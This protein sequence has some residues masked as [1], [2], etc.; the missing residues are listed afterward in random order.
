MLLAGELRHSG[1][2]YIVSVA[3]ATRLGSGTQ[4]PREDH[5]TAATGPSETMRHRLAADEGTDA[6]DTKTGL[7]PQRASVAAS[8]RL[9]PARPPTV[10]QLISLKRVGSPA[11][12]PDGKLRRLH[13]ARAQLGRERLR[14]RD[15]A[16]RRRDR[17]AP[18]VDQ[19]EE[20]ERVAELVAR[21]D[22]GSPSRPTA[23]TSSRSASSG[24]HA[25]RPN[26]SRPTRRR[27]RRLRLVARRQGRSPTR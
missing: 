24:R 22:D 17:H 9:G 2:G 27:R 10:D 26:R 5:R 23:P 25:A 14:N 7:C 21:R 8:G 6:Y 19:R 18:P 4:R 1:D 12:S 3:G 20:V 16:R 13:G 15:L 11:I